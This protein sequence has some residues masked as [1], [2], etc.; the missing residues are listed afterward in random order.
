[1]S[2][3]KHFLGNN[4]ISNFDEDLFNFK[5]YADKVKRIIQLNSSNNEP[6]TIGIYGKWGE[7]K[8][9]FLNLV[10]YNIE[11]FE[12]NE[13]GKEYLVFEF[14][15]W[16][17]S[18]EDE[19]LF[20][21]FDGI[22]KRFFIEQKTKI[23]KVGK[24]IIRYSRYLKAIKISTTIGI[25]KTLGTSVS[26]EPSKIFEA[27]GED[28]A[29][30]QITLEKLKDK[31]NEAIND[32][33]FKV[34]VFVDDLDRLDKNEIYTILKLIKLTANFDNFI[35][36]TTLDSEHVA[37]AIKERYG[38][39][40]EDGKLFLEKIINIP[41]HLPKIEE[42][43]L[44][45]FFEKKFNQIT[46]YLDFKEI[47]KK[48][49]EIKEIIQ[50]FSASKF[51]SPRE[52]IRVLNGFFI[53]AF[54]F[55]DEVNLTDLFW[56]EWI[57]VKNEDLY[58][59]IKKYNSFGTMAIFNGQ[60]V[61]IN[62]NDEINYGVAKNHSLI[63]EEEINGSRKEFID[64][65]PDFK[66]TLDLLFPNKKA[67]EVDIS[68]YDENLNINSVTHFNKYFS[69]HTERKIKN[70][71]IL[72][73]K[74][75]IAENDEFKLYEEIKE[76]IK[77]S[78]FNSFYTIQNLIR[79]YGNI[80]SNLECRDFFYEF[81]IKNISIIPNS[82][83]DMFGI[84]SR[85]RLI[86][87]IAIILNAD[88]KNDNEKTA[89]NIAQYLDVEELC[90]FT[91]KFKDEKTKFK[92]KLEKFISDKASRK[93]N[94]E[95]PIYIIPNNPVKMIMHYW[96]NNDEKGFNKHIKESLTDIE[97]VKKLIRN[98]P[99]FWNNSFYGGLQKKNYEY[100]KT[101]IDVVF[102]FSKIKELDDSLIRKIDINNYDYIDDVS[103]YNEE[104]NLEQFIYWFKKELN[105]EAFGS[106]R[107]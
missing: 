2:E 106:N 99:G 15:P 59:R 55:E 25:P 104:E 8:T 89:I 76:L 65:Y 28:L 37:K 12:K 85:I 33:N 46:K 71:T 101:L 83:E 34:I 93:F 3:N 84:D 77:N 62:F 68:I 41:I 97:R 23:Q 40:L 43:D 31:V 79:F 10:K 22:S 14:N 90:Y 94:N 24:Q 1:M 105:D 6:L 17:Y 58:T 61:I 51:N 75:F 95:N 16:R 78:G 80:N 4:P 86:E 29:G 107:K 87:L 54:G 82:N 27:L 103:E 20:D 69:F 74:K 63:N 18:D 72:K 13:K 42:E 35:F 47:E 21:F 38:D 60:N 30:E 88:E 81:I 73:I 98:F 48:Q 70:T 39:N 100:M 9:S 96:K 19:M 49:N 53:A 26:F 66:E 102:V 67:T 64:K 50:G 57:K 32:A 36:I 92:G 11:H 91:R 7:G 5:H 52:I 44:Q 56:I 45:Y